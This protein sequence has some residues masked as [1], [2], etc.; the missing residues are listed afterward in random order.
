MENLEK[1]KI[2]VERGKEKLLALEKEGVYVFHGTTVI[3]DEL[4]PK[5]GR[6]FDYKLKRMEND[7][8]PA[9]VA[10]P[11]AEVA[12]FRAIIN[13]KNEKIEAKKGKYWSEFSNNDGKLEFVTT[14]EVIELAKKV[15]GYVYVFKRDDFERRNSLEW[16]TIKSVKPIRVF[17]V[18]FND[19]PEGIKLSEHI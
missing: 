14:P 17:E 8:E 3:L 1:A 7:G 6:N 16:R 15:K 4:E 12:I 10:T 2:E 13:E 9:V 18:N 5:Q 19:L 11:F